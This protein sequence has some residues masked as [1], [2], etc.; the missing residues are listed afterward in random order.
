MASEYQSKM[1]KTQI[2]PLVLSLA[3]SIASKSSHD[4]G[5]NGIKTAIIP[6]VPF[7]D[8]EKAIMLAYGN[9]FGLEVEFVLVRSAIQAAELVSNGSVEIASAGIM[10]SYFSGRGKYADG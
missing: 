9:K 10:T 3:V 2:L 1:T 4:Q 8:A 7:G 6:R 5:N